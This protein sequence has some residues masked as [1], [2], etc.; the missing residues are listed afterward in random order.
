M[1]TK[2]SFKYIF[3][4]Q[5]W[6]SPYSYLAL[7][8]VCFKQRVHQSNKDKISLKRILMMPGTSPVDVP[9]VR[10]RKRE[11]ERDI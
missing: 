8:S 9:V 2:K 5:W 4:D 6:M 7:N 1:D 10:E 3:T 11:G